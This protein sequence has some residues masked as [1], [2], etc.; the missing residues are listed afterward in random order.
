[1]PKTSLSASVTQTTLPHWITSMLLFLALT[2]Y[3][4]ALSGQT[5]PSFQS[6]SIVIPHGLVG[7]DVDTFLEPWVIDHD[8]EDEHTYA[9]TGNPEWLT[10]SSGGH[11]TGIPPEAGTFELQVTVT[12]STNLSDE[13][14]FVLVVSGDNNEPNNSLETATPLQFSTL[15]QANIFLRDIDYYSIN[16]PSDGIVKIGINCGEPLLEGLQVSLVDPTKLGQALGGWVE[17]FFTR[18]V[19]EQQEAWVEYWFEVS[20]FEVAMLAVTHSEFSAL[21]AV[22]EAA[23]DYPYQLA[24]IFEPANGSEGPEV[25]D[26]NVNVAEAD[27]IL[28]QVSAE[29]SSDGEL[30]YSIVSA[31]KTASIGEE[32]GILS[33]TPSF[34]D[35][36]E[37]VIRVAVTEYVGT[38]EPGNMGA[39]SIATVTVDVTDVNRAPSVLLSRSELRIKAG[40]ELVFFVGVEDPDLDNSHAF[41]LHMEDTSPLP[42]GLT[43]D[44]ATG[45]V[46]WSPLSGDVGSYSLIVSV[47]DDA[48]SPLEGSA[49]LTIIVLSEFA[50]SES[51][52]APVDLIVTFPLQESRVAR[53]DHIGI[54]FSFFDSEAGTHLEAVDVQIASDS[55]FH[56]EV[57]SAQAVEAP[58]RIKF[59]GMAGI[60]LVGFSLEPETQYYIRVKVHNSDT[61]ASD[62]SQPAPFVTPAITKLLKDFGASDLSEIASSPVLMLPVEESI[63]LQGGEVEYFRIEMPTSHGIRNLPIQALFDTQS[64]R[65]SL[66]VYEVVSSGSE[67]SYYRL[68]RSAF[69]QFGELQDGLM[70]VLS[71][72]GV[73]LVHTIVPGET[74][75]VALEN[76]GDDP[77]HVQL[78]SK[79]DTEIDPDEK[80]V[81]GSNPNEEDEP[82]EINTTPQS[83]PVPPV[84]HPPLPPFGP[85]PEGFTD[86]CSW[87]VAIEWTGKVLEIDTGEDEYQEFS[88]AP[89]YWVVIQD[90]FVEYKYSLGGVAE[91]GVQR[92]ARYRG[93]DRSVPENG[94]VVAGGEWHL[95]AVR[96]GT[97][98]AGEVGASSYNAVRAIGRL[99]VRNM[100]AF[101]AIRFVESAK[102]ESGVARLVKA[103]PIWSEQQAQTGVA[104]EINSGDVPT[105]PVKLPTSWGDAI[106]IV[107][108]ALIAAA[109]ELPSRVL[110][111]QRDHQWAS[112]RQVSDRLNVTVR[113]HATAY[114]AVSRPTFTNNTL[115]HLGGRKNG[116]RRVTWT[117]THQADSGATTA[118]LVLAMTLNCI[119]MPNC[120]PS[121]LRILYT[122]AEAEVTHGQQLVRIVSGDGWKSGTIDQSSSITSTDSGISSIKHTMKG[123]EQEYI[124]NRVIAWQVNARSAF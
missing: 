42:E 75:L 33:W 24:A 14:T 77:I 31:P 60:T 108:L 87:E 115:L 54:S 105:Q 78:L 99:D 38:M 22:A 55:G 66:T 37:H 119:P 88:M 20:G 69:G 118:T 63:T 64:S 124:Q 19:Q 3:G 27:E 65:V 43:I 114:C 104:F 6:E 44:E 110:F 94:P 25:A 79:G 13:A 73:H 57:W 72:P 92:Q 98:G 74:L 5:A 32:D 116:Q 52:E 67:P 103:Q 80:R 95:S 93:A 46:S 45:E 120:P 36:G 84:F 101:N 123:G 56:N 109:E 70:R 76:H 16:V 62:W 10:L 106:E 7:Q 23:I 40:G 53:V 111:K 68:N 41:S 28:V 8:E 113:A 26:A 51:P 49:S 81:I 89:G 121:S 11:L 1:M 29:P 112:G 86:D 100:R 122:A 15:V 82:T 9:M 97:C 90:V 50:A 48:P 21:N 59:G 39:T 96:L 107:Q 35:A 34:T 61:V 102:L 47:I 4:A 12:D 17:A 58:G 85:P 91:A 83:N 30:R 18:R 117:G 2:A 71:V